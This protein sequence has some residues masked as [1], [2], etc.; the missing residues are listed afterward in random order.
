ML[1]GIAVV[2]NAVCAMSVAVHSN[3]SID[4][5]KFRPSA[6]EFPMTGMVP[7][8]LAPYACQ[9]GIAYVF[10]LWLLFTHSL[11]VSSEGSDRFLAELDGR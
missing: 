6:A 3:V 11:S 5:L 2:H 7:C 8:L 4:S 1:D 10:V 9:P